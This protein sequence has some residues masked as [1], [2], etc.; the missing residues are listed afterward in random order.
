[1]T[2]NFCAAR[3]DKRCTAIHPLNCE[4]GDRGP[5]I[6]HRQPTDQK[7][8]PPKLASLKDFNK[9]LINDY[10]HDSHFKKPVCFWV[11]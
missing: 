3:H 11:W 10:H 7:T 9:L 4:T 5:S 8:V 6:A 1:M 2:I